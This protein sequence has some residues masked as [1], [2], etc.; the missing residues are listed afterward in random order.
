[1]HI[2]LYMK[3]GECQ[4]TVFKLIF[5][6]FKNLVLEVWQQLRYPFVKY[7]IINKAPFK[8]NIRFVNQNFLLLLIW[9]YS[10]S[11]VQEKYIQ[12]PR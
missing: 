7:N 8:G 12:K 9:F 1:M 11:V 10:P 3:Q 6:S 2:Q 5:Y 4:K